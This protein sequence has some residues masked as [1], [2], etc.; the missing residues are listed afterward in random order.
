MVTS[1]VLFLVCGACHK[2][3]KACRCKAMQPT[4]LEEQELEADVE[5][6]QGCGRG[7]WYRSGGPQLCGPCKHEGG[8]HAAP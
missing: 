3:G 6:C 1:P 4:C 8:R 7:F 5:I 2:P